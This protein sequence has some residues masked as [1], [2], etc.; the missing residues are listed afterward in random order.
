[1]IFIDG[2]ILS[3]GAAA[4]V[5]GLGLVPS[6]NVGPKLALCEPVH[7]SAPDIAGKGIANPIA[8]IRAADML[9]DHLS[10]F[11]GVRKAPE[12][13]IEKAIQQ[14]LLEGPRTKD[15]GGNATTEEVTDAILKHIE[16]LK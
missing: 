9:L 2:D 11:E 6:A 13:V 8:T 5:G 10:N 16:K 4:L 7:G 15:L 3:D 14:V 12:G 1:L